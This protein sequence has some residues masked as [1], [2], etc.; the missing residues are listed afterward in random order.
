MLWTGPSFAA[1]PVGTLTGVVGRVDITGPDQAARPAAQGDPVAAHDIIRTKSEAR[2]EITFTD[3]SIVRVA[4][5]SRVE[6]AQY[7][8]ADDDTEGRGILTLFRGKLRSIIRKGKAGWFG[9]GASD[10][11][12]E[13][14]TPTMVSGVR[15]TDF[16]TTYQ[17]GV[18]AAVFREG[19]GY[20][21]PLNHPEEEW[22]I[23][24][25]EAMIIE[26]L[27][28]LPVIRQVS[29][30]ELRMHLEDTAISGG[31]GPKDSGAKPDPGMEGG[32]AGELTRSDEGGTPSESPR[33]KMGAGPGFFRHGDSLRVKESIREFAF[34]IDLAEFD[35]GEFYELEADP[36]G[37]I[38]IRLPETG[39][40]IPMGQ[41]P[42]VSRED[43]SNYLTETWD[44][45]VGNT[46]GR[47]FD[48]ATEV[49]SIFVSPIVRE[50]T[51]LTDQDWR[52]TNA[53]VAGTYQ[54]HQ[55]TTH[56]AWRLDLEYLE[57]ATARFD[58]FTGTRW[59]E[60]EIAADAASAWVDWQSCLTGIGGGRLT[61]SFD[62]AAENWQGTG[63]WVSIPT[64][65]YFDM[66]ADGGETLRSLDIPA[67][68]IGRATLT[69]AAGGMEV[70]LADVAFMGYA[71][72]GAPALWATRGVSGAFTGSPAEPVPLSGGG[73]QAEFS[74][75]KWQ[76]GCWSGLVENG[77]GTLASSME[78]EFRGGAAGSFDMDSRTFSG[79]AVG[80]AGQV[81][82]Q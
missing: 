72:G 31:D 18:S 21:Y 37:R 67:V 46:A 75:Q 70:T 20:G 80:T 69:G 82:G 44:L 26:G 61:G 7:T 42:G 45:Y 14:K 28:A 38:G 71:T 16:F 65:Q 2:A 19:E 33:G 36:D 32:P 29:A 25:G 17:R 10:R 23:E 81:L 40:F 57:G 4:P 78:I 77:S 22:T 27:D 47:F 12:F 76:N 58:H 15:G 64:D 30:L 43:L 1:Q 35:N 74:V 60:G 34:S 11:S 68:E 50:D 62:P 39:E 6:I 24:A 9:F 56:D 66:L 5:A 41:I 52:I 59:S 13:V 8:L 54:D 73:L 3:G 53:F 51:R 48:G 63:R 55:G 79:S 49:G